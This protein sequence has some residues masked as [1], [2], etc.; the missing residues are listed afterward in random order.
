MFN[1]LLSAIR[2]NHDD[3][4]VITRRRYERRGADKC[5]SIIN[6]RAYPVENWSL[7]GVLINGDSRPFGIDNE[8]DVTLRFKMRDR[9]MDVIHRGRVVR[10]S[11]DSV[12]FE[13]MPLTTQIKNNFQSVIDDFVAGQF[14]DSQLN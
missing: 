13:F 5:I 11:K 4:P 9:V 1:S 10:K 2:T 12:A 7:G 8:I 6:G 3:D 14:A